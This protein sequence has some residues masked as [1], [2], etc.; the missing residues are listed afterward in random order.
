MD[1]AD[2]TYAEANLGPGQK[3]NQGE[4]KVLG[5]RWDLASDRFVVS[6][7]ITAASL[8]PTKRNI[9]WWANFTTHL[10]SLPLLSCASRC[11][12]K[13]SARPNS[14]GISHFPAILW[15]ALR[16]GLEEGQSISI[17]RCYLDGV[18]ECLISSTLCGFCDA[19]V[20]AS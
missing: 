4:K 12:S 2:E 15:C 7:G 3:A 6:L 19:S 1:E 9:I 20:K 11:F 14:T 13:S 5:V 16:S 17:P 18:S 10:G 8:E